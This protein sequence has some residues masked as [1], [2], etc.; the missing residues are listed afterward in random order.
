[1]MTF[2]EWIARVYVIVASMV[3]HDAA[4]NRLQAMDEGLQ[5]FFVHNYSSTDAANWIL[6][7]DQKPC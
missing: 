1:M 4:T 5:S 6:M 7:R 2:N 3:G